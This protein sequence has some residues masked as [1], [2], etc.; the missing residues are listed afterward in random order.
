[1]EQA[2]VVVMVQLVVLEHLVLVARAAP[3]V[4]QLQVVPAV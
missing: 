2:V 3:V 1:V 4:Q